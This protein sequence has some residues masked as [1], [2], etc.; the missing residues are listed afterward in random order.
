MLLFLTRTIKFAIQGFFRNFWLSIVTIIILV[1]TLF[2]ITMVAGINVV[3]DQAI[4]S[5]QDRVDVSIY[6]KQDTA[7]QD[8][9]AVRDTLLALPQV[10][11]VVYVSKDD[12]LEKFRKQHED[13]S[14]ILDAI[15]QLE[16]NPLSATIVIKASS[17]DEYSAIIDILDQPQYDALIEERSFDNNQTVIERLS[18][19]SNRIEQVGIIVSGIFVLIAVL[20]IF[21]TI[22][23]NIYTHREEIGIMKLVGGSNAFVRMPFIIE[24]FLY[25]IVAVIITLLILYPVL[26]VIAPQLNSFFE[27]YD[28]DMIQYVNDN[29]VMLAGLQLL[30][31]ILLSGISSSIA[32]GRYLKV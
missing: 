5:V 15:D 8:A 13:D 18:D 16:E 21:N 25:A 20:I 14:V 11:E 32:I 7:E 24:T 2:S 30:F 26:N 4:S 27:G 6:F 22:R 28:L 10:K 12:A 3:A 17:I 1:L 19:V 9:I 29:L 31:A 23:I